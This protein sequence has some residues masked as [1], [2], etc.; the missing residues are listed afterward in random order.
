M[1][2][3]TEYHPE[4]ASQFHLQDNHRRAERIPWENYPV[5]VEEVLPYRDVIEKI[6]DTF[7]S[8]HDSDH[9]SGHILRTL[10]Y[11]LKLSRYYE[12]QGYEVDE[13]VL[14]W[15][16]ILH[17]IKSN[18]H[19]DREDPDNH[20]F[21]GAVY[22]EPFVK[23]GF[24]P[25]KARQITENVRWHNKPPN[26]VPAEVATIEHL[27]LRAADS[28]ELGR[29]KEERTIIVFVDE[30]RQMAPFAEQLIAQ[31][32]YQ[33]QGNTFDNITRAALDAGLLVA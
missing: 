18:H 5:S 20:G 13:E 30:A 2:I 6:Y 25:D 33:F 7:P 29:M 27:I 9:D 17:D 12:G 21:M 15:S 8:E 10:I 1:L 3:K 16:V 31:T 19:E 24:T 11:A 22:V 4:L 14:T 32:V 23:S 28:L 26:A